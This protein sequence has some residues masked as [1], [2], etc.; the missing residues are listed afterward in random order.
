MWQFK[1][2]KFAS[3]YKLMEC[4][5]QLSEIQLVVRHCEA[6]GHSH[7]MDFVLRAYSNDL[8][9]ISSYSRAQVGLEVTHRLLSSSFLGLPYRILNTS[10]RK[11]LLRRV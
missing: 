6:S 2:C 4:V 7:C 5:A 1:F 8:T 11:E 10:P 3:T 9:P